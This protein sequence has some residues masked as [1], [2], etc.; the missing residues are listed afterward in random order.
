L[1]IKAMAQ[2]LRPILGGFSISLHLATFKSFSIGWKFG[3]LD[4]AAVGCC[5]NR[6]N[7]S[8]AHVLLPPL[9]ELFQPHHSMGQVFQQ[10][11]KGVPPLWAGRRQHPAGKL[12][13]CKFK[14]GH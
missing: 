4:A 13:H 14:L 3:S 5:F 7:D 6:T 8:N 1:A 2:V 10:A 11:A 12:G 9:S